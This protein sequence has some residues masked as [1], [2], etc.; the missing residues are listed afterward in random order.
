MATTKIV[1][2]EDTENLTIA[3]SYPGATQEYGGPW[4][5][6]DLHVH[7][8]VPEGM[9]ADCVKAQMSAEKWTKEGEADVLVDPQDPS[10]TYVASAPELVLDQA[11]VDAKEQKG[12]DDKLALLRRER[13]E[14]A[15][16]AD[17]EI[18][19]HYDADANK[20]GLEAD[21]KAYR[22]ALRDVTDAYKDTDPMVGTAALDAFEADMSDFSGWPTKPS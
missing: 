13:D 4:G 1:N 21:W 22:V 6:P 9:D 19:K 18:H 5:N 14:K 17:H 11:L 10:W 15:M 20:I 16:E 12:R 3:S 7:L 8:Q 2:I